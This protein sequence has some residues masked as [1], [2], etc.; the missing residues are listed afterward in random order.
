MNER[1]SKKGIFGTVVTAVVVVA[2]I[3]SG[4]VFSEFNLTVVQLVNDG[5]ADFDPPVYGKLNAC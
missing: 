2:L 1:N 3:V 4:I 5:P